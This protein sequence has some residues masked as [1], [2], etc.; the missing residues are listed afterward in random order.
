VPLQTSLSQAINSSVFTQLNKTNKL[1]KKLSIMK[2]Q[3]NLTSQ[4]AKSPEPALI[5]NPHSSHPNEYIDLAPFLA[6]IINDHGE[7]PENPISNALAIFRDTMKVLG[8][9]DLKN[10]ILPEE[11]RA[12]LLYFL[13]SIEDGLSRCKIVR[14]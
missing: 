12:D 9:V 3:L 11:S 5:K 14:M 10:S 1:F 4:L 7:D 2:I 6:A 8:T 13:Y